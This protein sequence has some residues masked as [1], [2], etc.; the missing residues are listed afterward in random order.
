MFRHNIRLFHMGG[1]PIELNVSWVFILSLVTW[2]FA[3]GYYPENFPGLFSTVQL[4]ILGLVTAL[5][6]FVSIIL[7][8]FS[9]SIVASRNGLPIKRIT[10][11]MFGGIAQMSRDVDDPV[12]EFKMA[13]AG[14]LMSLALAVVFYIISLASRNVQYAYAITRS[15]AEIN[16][17]LLIF[18]MVPGFPL[19][20]GRILRAL[21]WRKTGDIVLATRISSR[22]GSGFA[23]FLML[24]GMLAFV[25]LQSFISGLW[26]I[27]IGFFLKRATRLG[28]IMAAYR[29]ALEGKSVADVM[30]RDIVTAGVSL[31]LETVVKEYFL[32]HRLSSFPVADDRILVGMV[33]LEDIRRVD[34]NMWVSTTVG[35]VMRTEPAV[36]PLRLSDPAERALVEIMRRKS[37]F[38]PV[39]DHEWNIVGM[40]TRTGL[41]D[42]IKVMSSLGK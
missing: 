31:D 22:I 19:D 23:I 10:L 2:T 30:R 20:G 32:R 38:F 42:A 29:S 34:R 1:I 16:V 36:N 18:N 33:S 39:V 35:Q 25:W 14:P 6:L 40:V 12:L 11:F 7:H 3:S 17:G 26:L 41:F 8:E 5:L 13:A 4:W 37:E 24:L 9:H 28:Y 15:L 27:F 21:I